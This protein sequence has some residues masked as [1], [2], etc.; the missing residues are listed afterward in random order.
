M[1]NLLKDIWF[2]IKDFFITTPLLL[3]FYFLLFPFF[4]FSITAYNI[5]ASGFGCKVC[6]FIN[7]QFPLSEEEM[8]DTVAYFG[9]LGF[10]IFC[11]FIF[12][13]GIFY[14]NKVLKRRGY[15]DNEEENEEKKFF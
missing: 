1:K 11:A 3:V 12:G 6:L 14:V 10:N 13:A 5:I 8:A 4:Y 9:N 7:E 2:Y 15:N